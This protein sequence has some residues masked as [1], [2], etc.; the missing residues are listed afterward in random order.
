MPNPSL[1]GAPVSLEFTKGHVEPVFCSAA[2]IGEVVTNLVFNAVDAMPRGGKITIETRQESDETVIEVRDT[3]VGIPEAVME[4]I[5]TPFFT[6]K[7]AAGA[8]MGLSVARE[9][10]MRHGGDILAESRLGDGSSFTV[11]LPSAREAQVYQSKE[12]L[13]MEEAFHKAKNISI[14]VIEDEESIRRLL[15]SILGMEG[16]EVR[17]SSNAADGLAHF[18]E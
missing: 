3:G 15:A 16:H 7:D 17:S 2:E 12:E 4:K 9:I 6:T 11:R 18:R 10:V 8:G 13:R 14:L 5:F 1:E